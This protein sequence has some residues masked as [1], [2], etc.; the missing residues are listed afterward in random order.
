[1][2]P[3][4]WG[5]LLRRRHRWHERQGPIPPLKSSISLDQLDFNLNKSTSKII[6]YL[7]KNFLPVMTIMTRGCRARSRFYR[8]KVSLWLIYAGVRVPRFT[9][10]GVLT[11]VCLPQN[12]WLL[13]ENQTSNLRIKGWMFWIC[14]PCYTQWFNCWCSFIVLDAFLSSLK[15]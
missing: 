5:L 4:A 9:P 8:Q 13:R 3:S 6:T 2:L 1:M 12:R 7:I 15:Y 10:V 11:P 14:S